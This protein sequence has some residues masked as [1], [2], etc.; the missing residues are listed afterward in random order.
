VIEHLV[1]GATGAHL[2]GSRGKRLG[3]RQRG[4]HASP[5]GRRS[6][7]SCNRSTRRDD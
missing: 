1:K 2:L 5:D 6:A 3:E 7:T 4:G